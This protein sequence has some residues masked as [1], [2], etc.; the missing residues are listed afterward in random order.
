MLRT[1]NDPHLFLKNS[2]RALWC[3]LIYT[4]G[5]EMYPL[6]RCQDYQPCSVYSLFPYVSQQEI[7]TGVYDATACYEIIPEM[8][9]DCVNG[10][11]WVLIN[12]KRGCSKE[13]HEYAERTQIWTW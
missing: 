4:N 3:S 2:L 7:G 6:H 9:S 11:S 8:S 1:K 12:L 13:S 10:S 5:P